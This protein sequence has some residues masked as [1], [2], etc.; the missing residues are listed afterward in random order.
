MAILN[1]AFPMRA[2]QNDWTENPNDYIELIFKGELN[3]SDELDIDLTN[4]VQAGA[5]VSYNVRAVDEIDPTTN[6]LTTSSA[7]PTGEG[8]AVEVS[9]FIKPHDLSESF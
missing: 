3:A 9:V 5:E 2:L 7:V 4:I 6:I 1:N 8:T